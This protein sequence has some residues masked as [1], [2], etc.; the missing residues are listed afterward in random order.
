MKILQN[1]VQFLVEV[2]IIFEKYHGNLSY[3]HYWKVSH[4]QSFHIF[5]NDN[6]Y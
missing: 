1:I 4:K 2:C 6:F 5:I 3:G